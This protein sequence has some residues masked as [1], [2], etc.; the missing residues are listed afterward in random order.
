MPAERLFKIPATAISGIAM[1]IAIVGAS[2]LGS[3]NLVWWA[4][5][6]AFVVLTTGFILEIRRARRRKSV[7][8]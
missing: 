6:F 8:P 7:G 4:V 2:V 5:A 1:L 3:F